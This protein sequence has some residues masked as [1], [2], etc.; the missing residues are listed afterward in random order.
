MKKVKQ[1][2]N[3]IIDALCFALTGY[4]EPPK[5]NGKDRNQ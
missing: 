3:F 4:Y 2:L 1:F 5:N